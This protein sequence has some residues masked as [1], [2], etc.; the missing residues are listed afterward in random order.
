MKIM[1]NKVAPFLLGGF[2][3]LSAGYL[4]LPNELKK[5]KQKTEEKTA[6]SISSFFN[7]IYDKFKSGIQ[8][9]QTNPVVI[10]NNSQSGDNGLTKNLG[11]LGGFGAGGLGLGGLSVNRAA[12]LAANN[13]P[14]P[15]TPEALTKAE[16]FAKAM[17]QK[18]PTKKLLSY[19][20]RGSDLMKSQLFKPEVTGGTGTGRDFMRLLY[21][22]T[23][24]SQVM[25]DM[26]WTP[27]KAMHYGQFSKGPIRAYMQLVKEMDEFKDPTELLNKLKANTTPSIGPNGPVI[28][29][30]G[31]EL[32]D[33]Y[34]KRYGQKAYPSTDIG[35]YHGAAIGYQLEELA[36]KNP[37]LLAKY[38]NLAIDA[39]SVTKLSPKEQ[40]ALLRE[41]SKSDYGKEVAKVFAEKWKQP[42]SQYSTLVKSLAGSKNLIDQ[43]KST[44][45]NVGRQGRNA[46]LLSLPLM[47]GSAGLYLA[48]DRAEQLRDKADSE[49]LVK[50]ILSGL[51][52]NTAKSAGAYLLPPSKPKKKKLQSGQEET[53]E[54]NKQAAVYAEEAFLLQQYE[55]QKQLERN[56]FGNGWHP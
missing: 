48:G 52:Q 28:P 32:V 27:D 37:A 1:N 40:L 12:N 18:D 45:T 24:L 53:A 14:D 2:N 15:F 29:R 51:K 26:K 20:G 44:L 39:Q 41:F 38:P 23:P 19:V 50:N 49:M 47:A 17:K 16:R 42:T 30:T 3:K 56:D 6:N 43:A 9:P 34:G 8:T 5:K 4:I 55:M 36:K 11:I 35:K 46:A 31:D 25:P 22:K 33:L 21:K 13:V 7:N 10:V 54:L